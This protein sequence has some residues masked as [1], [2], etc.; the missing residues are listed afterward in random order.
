MSNQIRP[1][2]LISCFTILWNWISQGPP[3]A[4]GTKK[5]A[6]MKR[7]KGGKGKGKDGAGT[8][9]ELLVM[10]FMSQFPL[11]ADGADPLSE[12]VIKYVLHLHVQSKESMIAFNIT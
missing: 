3:T 9:G 6:A 1:A 4:G 2:H 12:D 11:P 8:A 7:K 5:T 10:P